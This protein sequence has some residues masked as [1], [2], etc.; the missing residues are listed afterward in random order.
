MIQ[1]ELDSRQKLF[2]ISAYASCTN[3][4]KIHD[5]LSIIFQKLKLHE[6]NNKYI[7]IGDLNARHNLWG[8]SVNNTKG[9]Q[10]NKWLND[11][12]FIYNSKILHSLQPTYKN[13][14]SYIDI[15]ICDK[16]LKTKEKNLNLHDY[17]SDHFAISMTLQLESAIQRSEN[18]SQ[19]YFLYKKTKWAKFTK[20]IEKKYKT[21]LPNNINLT[22]EEIDKQIEELESVIRPALQKATPCYKEKSHLEDLSKSKKIQNLYKKKHQIQTKIHRIRHYDNFHYSQ[23][24]RQLNSQL[25]KVK[26]DLYNEFKKATNDNWNE[27]VRSINYKDS[28]NF[29]PK[30]NKIFKKNM[31]NQSIKNI[32]ISATE[33]AIL[34]EKNIIFNKTNANAANRINIDDEENLPNII[35]TLFERINTE[36][37]PDNSPLEK[38]IKKKVSEIK[39]E[40]AKLT[41]FT[42]FSA[43]NKSTNPTVTRDNVIHF[44][45]V[46]EV[47]RLIKWM[48]NKT[49]TG[50]DEIPNV[51]LKRLPYIC[52][53]NYTIIFNNCINNAYFP[54]VWKLAKLIVL[55]KKS[56]E[57][58]SIDNFRPISMLPA[59]S[60]IF[61]R[62]INQIIEK[63]SIKNQI[64]PPQQF[65]FRKK[66]ATTHAIHK[67]VADINWHMSKGDMVGAV[68]I[69]LK[70][71]FDSVW[72]EGLIYKLYKF[73]TP[74]HLLKLIYN[75]ITNRSF[76]ISLNG[77]I[78]ILF[79]ITK[80]LQQGTVISPALFNIYSADILRLFDLNNNKDTYGIAFADDL[81]AYLGNKKMAVIEENL[82][83]IYNKISIYYKN[84]KLQVNPK[85]C[86]TILFRD[87]LEGKDLYTRKNWR[88]FEIK[89]SANN[90]AIPHK[91]V[92]KYLGVH[93]DDRLKFNEHLKI[94]LKKA[95][96][97]FNKLH[98]L[99]YHKHL[100]KRANSYRG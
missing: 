28:A 11:N 12:S 91:R 66:H 84:W 68:L 54:T 13:A 71:A 6:L 49:S 83:K 75:M 58:N 64:I 21:L 36:D 23:E 52:I 33:A 78:S 95:K 85:K 92:V 16:N 44:T 81:I 22:N 34:T 60:K 93:L 51:A 5:D 82:Q 38:I 59:I 20:E 31:D 79:L 96:D 8:D 76:K 14:D 18:N 15:A 43:T 29:F 45:N 69:D 47:A 86:E 97:T 10:L 70:K 100:D 67:L 80:G 24:R 25:N 30:L 65:G 37:Q 3:K 4:E 26:I 73:G 89:D 2:I 41:T 57:P 62:I 27:L 72:H 87:I 98:R 7:I 32:E 48:S 63:F 1:L 56:N 61:E 35:G 77:I 17:E 39:E 53:R 46:R 90:I 9:S 40:F 94:Q 19:P 50:W 99:F 55:I 74:A 42:T 88:K